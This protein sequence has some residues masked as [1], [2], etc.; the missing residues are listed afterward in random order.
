MPNQS[1]RVTIPS[2]PLEI[3][4]LAKSIVAKH[5]ADGATSPLGQLKIGV[6]SFNDVMARAEPA[7]SDHLEAKAAE[8]KADEKFRDRD[9]KLASLVTMIRLSR[10]LLTTL[11]PENRKA[12]GEW[13]FTVDDTPRRNIPS[14]SEIAAPA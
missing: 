2:N 14:E 6:D 4:D 8:R 10:D 11:H 3:I 1:S 7:Q 13:G 5:E 12:L 9:V